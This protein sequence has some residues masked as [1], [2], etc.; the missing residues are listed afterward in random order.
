[1]P[2]VVFLISPF[3]LW[4]GRDRYRRSPPQGSVLPAALRIWRYAQRG[5]WSWNPFKTLKNLT[6]SDFWESAKPSKQVCEKPQWM[7]F[8]DQWVDEVRRGFKAC[9]VFVWFPLYCE[10]PLLILFITSSLITCRAGLCYNQLNNN[11]ISQAATMTTNGLPNDILSNLD[12]FAL[13]IFIPICDLV[14]RNHHCHHHHRFSGSQ[15]D[16]TDLPSSCTPWYQIYR[17][18]ENCMGLRHSSCIDDL[19]RCRAILP[20]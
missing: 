3:V 20:L 11:L 19:G 9:G 18:E 7:T 14:V 5:R 15:C 12:P 6:A 10:F 16:N 1:M 2:T 8:D 17:F 13:I 4:F